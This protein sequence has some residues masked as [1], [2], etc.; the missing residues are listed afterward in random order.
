[1]APQPASS[2]DP[3][4]YNQSLPLTKRLYPLG[5]PVDLSTNSEEVLAA[6]NAL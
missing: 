4:G 2:P 5:C 6:A 1:M 3:L